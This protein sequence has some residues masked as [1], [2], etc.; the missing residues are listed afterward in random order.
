MSLGI[1]SSNILFPPTPDHGSGARR[2]QLPPRG[3]NLPKLPPL[4]SDFASLGSGLRTPPVDDMSAAFQPAL[5][6]Y[7]SHAMYNYAAPMPQVAR[8]KAAAI[9][10]S[11]NSQYYRGALLQQPQQPQQGQQLSSHPQP[12]LQVPP[13][14]QHTNSSVSSVT[15][16]SSTP[17]QATGPS[18]PASGSIASVMGSSTSRRGS[19]SLVYHSLQ[20]PKCISPSG[21]NLADF[22]AQVS[23]PSRLQSSQGS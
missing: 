18:S 4:A 2:F 15:Q 3:L 19:E 5:A 16:L 23:F 22:A 20:I 6:S 14:T 17:Q 10:D 13:A 11:K 8:A 9:G 7:D 1:P 21:G 12:A